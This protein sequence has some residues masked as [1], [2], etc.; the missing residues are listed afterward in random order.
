MISS[1]RCSSRAVSLW[2]LFKS[3]SQRKLCIL[4]TTIFRPSVS[5]E[6]SLPFNHRGTY[7]STLRLRLRLSAHS[8]LR[9]PFVGTLGLAPSLVS[10]ASPFQGSL[11]AGRLGPPRQAREPTL[12]SAAVHEGGRAM[13]QPYRLTA[14]P[15]RVRSVPTSEAK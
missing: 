15:R 6:P 14:R 12:P 7:S 13:P 3:S 1:F 4:L 9:P 11:S 8:G 2:D 10:N 5:G